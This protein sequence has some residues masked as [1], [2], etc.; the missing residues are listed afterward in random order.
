MK[1]TLYILS[2]LPGSGKST[3]GK[4]LASKMGAAY[5]R[6]DTIEQ[7]LRESCAINV[8][9]EGYILG[10]RIA[11]DV[12]EN[13]AS[14]VADSCNPI[15]I[16]RAAWESVAIE[17]RAEFK[18]IEITCSNVVEHK[19]RVETR[20]CEVEGLKMPTWADVEKRQ[21]EPWTTER[22]V[23]DT[24]KQAEE[25]SLRLLLEKIQGK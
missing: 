9:S 16:T 22:I 11:K 13:G 25:E 12:L 1:P 18:N 3:L 21:Y 20:S 5:L 14:V 24:S 17:C 8:G 10:Y 6:I 15:Q 2:G 7:A 4:K 19:R 23:V